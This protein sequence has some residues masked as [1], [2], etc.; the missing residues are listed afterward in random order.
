MIIRVAGRDVVALEP[1][2]ARRACL[3]PEP[4]G[5]GQYWC[6]T[7]AERGCPA[8]TERNRRQLSFEDLLQRGGNT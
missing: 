5:G 4:S 7:R 6:R 3:V 8:V 1:E 2:C